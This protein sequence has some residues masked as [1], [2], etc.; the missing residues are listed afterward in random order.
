MLSDGRGG[1]ARLQRFHGWMEQ[2]APRRRRGKGNQQRQPEPSPEPEP[3]E[4]EQ[5]EEEFFSG[6]E[7][8]G[9]LVC[10]DSF[11]MRSDASES[12]AVLFA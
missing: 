10:G 12:K 9:G 11:Q 2:R 1:S 6:S 5:D 4:P 7:D 3:P 8:G